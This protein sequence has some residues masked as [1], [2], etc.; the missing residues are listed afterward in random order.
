MRLF[1]YVL[2]LVG[3]AL[4]AYAAG[5]VYNSKSSSSR[6]SEASPIYNAK[7]SSRSS[8]PISIK[9]LAKGNTARGSYKNYDSAYGFGRENEKKYTTSMSPSQIKAKRAQDQARA[10][11]YAAQAKARSEQ[12]RREAKSRQAQNRPETVQDKTRELTSRFQD[13]SG[14][15]AATTTASNVVPQRQAAPKRNPVFLQRNNTD[16]ATPKRV[17]NSNF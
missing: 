2:L 17:F 3:I 15:E 12:R 13:P 11:R 8:G 5:P 10:Q 14:E 6:S 9:N 4:P 1:L 16:P 7:S